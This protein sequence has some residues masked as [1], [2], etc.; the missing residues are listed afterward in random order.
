MALKTLQDV[1]K[2][3]Q[4]FL[5]KVAEQINTVKQGRPLSSDLPIREQENLLAQAS[6][7]LDAV[8]RAREAAVKRFDEEIQPLEETVTRLKAE[9]ASGKTLRQPAASK[10]EVKPTLATGQQEAPQSAAAEASG[11]PADKKAR[12]ARKARPT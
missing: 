3:Q 4:E 8:R 9:I 7:R 10:V 11:K 12:E 1:I 5:Q 6:T 2:S